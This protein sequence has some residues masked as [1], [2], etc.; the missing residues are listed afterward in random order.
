MLNVYVSVFNIRQ[1]QKA[2]NLRLNLHKYASVLSDY[3]CSLNL[4]KMVLCTR[5]IKTVL[6]IIQVERLAKNMSHM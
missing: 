4:D 3:K 2:M 1:D 6:S 5:S